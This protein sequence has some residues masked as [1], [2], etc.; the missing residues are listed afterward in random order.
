MKNCKY[1]EPTKDAIK[2]KKDGVEKYI[3]ESSKAKGRSAKQN[4][5]SQKDVI[6]P[7]KIDVHVGDIVEHI[8]Y[9]KG[10]VT[11]IGDGHVIIS[12]S[13]VDKRFYY[14][15]AFEKGQLK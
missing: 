13:D 8:V 10:K 5:D 6:K 14:P 11:K 1:F 3:K 7:S 4:K 12:F 9:G 15:N 2:K